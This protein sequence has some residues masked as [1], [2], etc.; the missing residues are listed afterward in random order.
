MI[1]LHKILDKFETWLWVKFGI[2]FS[3]PYS[4]H[5]CMKCNSI[6]FCIQSDI[7]IEMIQECKY[8]EDGEHDDYEVNC[9]CNTKNMNLFQIIKTRFN[10]SK[11]EDIWQ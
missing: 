2:K 10:F 6:I 4:H 7:E 1:R 11:G 5:V 3:E 9:N 8:S